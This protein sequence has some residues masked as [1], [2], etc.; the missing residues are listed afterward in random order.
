EIGRF[1]LGFKSVLGVTLEPVFFSR[2]G[3]FAFSQQRSE[4]EILAVV[5]NAE[6]VPYLRIAEPI[7]PIAHA[8]ADTVLSQLMTWATSVVV[9]PLKDA[10]STWLPEDI[11]KFPPEFLLFSPHVGALDFED[12]IAGLDRQIRLKATDGSILLQEG[13]DSSHWKAFKKIHKP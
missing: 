2:T 11:S 5:K 12:R 9:L 6:R 1:G 10:K 8:R 13:E 3:S 7:D 4:K